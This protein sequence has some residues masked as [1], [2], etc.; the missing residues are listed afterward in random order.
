MQ[1]IFLDWI[2]E[3]ARMSNPPYVNS[4]SYG[5]LA[6]EDPRTDVLTF[7]S[8]ACK[9]GLRGVTIVVASGDDGAANF[10]AR[11]DPT[12][13]GFTPS[14]PATSPFV[15]AVGATQGVEAG[16]AELPCLSNTNGGITSGGGASV[17]FSQ[18]SYQ[19]TFV[20]NYF[21]QLKAQGAFPPTSQW[22]QY[23][24]VYPDVAAAGHNFPIEVGGSQYMGS[25]T[26]AS[27]P[28][29]A[30]LIT[31]VNGQR[32]ANGKKP[33]GFLNPSLYAMAAK[34]H[35]TYYNNVTST[36]MNNCCAGA[37]GQAT[38]CQYGFKALWPFN[39]VTG[40]GSPNFA[41]FGAYLVNL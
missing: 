7:N 23:G 41:N 14:F 18:P 33:I 19:A 39:A 21:A 2:N 10:G 5:S 20:K 24:R 32:V 9:L 29:F 31:L 35:A 27:A 11:T 30:S 28:F 38:C 12:Q 17:Y 15:T 4:I 34:A 1:D 26:S 6:P 8:Q 16:S 40:L 13:C 22:N 36:L 37:Q 3:I 25:G